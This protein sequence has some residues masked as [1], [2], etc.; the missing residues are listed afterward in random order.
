MATDAQNLQTMKS[1]LL[2]YLA[3]E[4][5]NPKPSYSAPNGQSVSWDSHR[6]S[7]MQQVKEIDQQLAAAGGPWEEVAEGI[8]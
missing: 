3:T 4:S 6:T 5:A 8:T 7:I 2:A 1:N